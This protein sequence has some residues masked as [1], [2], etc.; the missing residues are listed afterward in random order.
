MIVRYGRHG[1]STKRLSVKLEQGRSSCFAD[2]TVAVLLFAMG[3]AFYG[4]LYLRHEDRFL[5]YQKY[6]FSAVNLYCTGDPDTRAVNSH[7]Q[8]LNERINLALMNCAEIAQS[9]KVAPAQFNGWHDTHPIMS[10]MIAMLWKYYEFSWQALWPMAGVLGGLTILSFYVVLRSFA[11]PLPAAALLLPTTIAYPFVE[12]NFYYLRDFSKAPFL[13]LSFALTGPLFAPGTPLRRRLWLLFGATLVVVVGSGFRQDTIVMMPVIVA[14]ALLTS[15]PTDRQGVLVLLLGLLTII[16]TYLATAHALSLLKTSQAM[17]LQG[18]P[19]FV[20]QGFGDP[21]L[22]EARSLV[23]GISFLTLYSD[24]LAWALVDANSPA[25][26]RYFVHFDDNYTKSGFDLIAKYAALSAADTLTRAFQTLSVLFHNNWLVRSPGIW[27]L[28]LF[29]LVVLGRWRIGIF[30]VF[31]IFALNTAGSLQFSPRHL[32]HLI[33]LDRILIVIVGA[34]Y[35]AVAWQSILSR[36][37]L[38]PMLAIGIATASAMTLAL[39]IVGAHS[40]QQRA[41]QDLEAKLQSLPWFPSREAYA[42]A[43]PNRT[44]SILRI[45]VGGG[46]CKVSS[47]DASI[48]NEGQRVS[49]S[50]D[51]TLGAPRPLY[52]GLLEPRIDEIKAEIY[53]ADC[54]LSKAWGPLGD[55]TITPLQFFDPRAALNANT[56]QRHFGQVLSALP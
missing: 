35:I 2:I 26:V 14:A 15:R 1:T 3:F 37:T 52:F 18:Y 43:F 30:L 40:I 33:M 16:A 34:T 21:F 51:L 47:V 41:V 9:P 8:E 32:L 28:S 48:I 12:Q 44:E 25:K 55:G 38:R 10:S 54:I 22:A 5:F 6:F 7:S 27:L 17:Q 4:N 29:G 49:R 31:A 19:H 36:P 39:I 13:I 42:E 24:M 46:K 23:P 20:I 53:P 45:V 50:V 56:L 11:I